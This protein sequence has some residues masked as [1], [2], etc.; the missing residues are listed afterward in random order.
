M[1]L[2][3][4]A[5]FGLN[6]QCDQHPKDLDGEVQCEQC[7]AVLVDAEVEATLVKPFEK[8][9]NRRSRRA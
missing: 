3:G 8:H 9:L 5:G 6:L 4:A 7:Q 2:D 1:G